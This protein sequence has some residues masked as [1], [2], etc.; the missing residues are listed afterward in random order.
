M[1]LNDLDPPRHLPSRFALI[2]DLGQKWDRAKYSAQIDNII[3]I[4]KRKYGIDATYE[5]E[6]KAFH[7]ILHRVP[8]ETLVDLI[9]ELD[10]KR[11]GRI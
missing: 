8:T 3:Q 1:K 5:M 7:G 4:F 2:R 9:N 11:H 6:G 10:N